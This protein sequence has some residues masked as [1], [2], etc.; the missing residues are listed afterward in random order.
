MAKK[1][2]DISSKRFGRLIALHVSDNTVPESHLSKWAC[3]CD[4]GKFCEARRRNLIAGYKK[5][6]GCLFNENL[7]TS[8]RM[9]GKKG[10]EHPSW[11]GKSAI[12]S[13]GYVCVSR[14][15]GGRRLEHLILMESHIGRELLPEE[16]VH[17]KNGIRHDNRIEN[18][19]LWTGKHCAGSRVDD[20]V[21]YALYVL[22][23]YRP[24]L[25]HNG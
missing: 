4:C 16:T 25:I 17:H 8:E 2:L 18:L 19:E 5:S 1:C 13:K 20:L 10:K 3:M 9:K 21:D 12:T 23:T 6:C 11:L 15:E 7:I 24:E 22:K 14:P